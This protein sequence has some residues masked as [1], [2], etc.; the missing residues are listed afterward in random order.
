MINTFTLSVELPTRGE[1]EVEIEVTTKG[2][3]ENDG[4]GAYEYWGCKGV[5]RGT[6]YFYI[7]EWDWNKTGFSPDEIKSVEAAIEANVDKWA[8]TVKMDEP[9]YDDWSE[10]RIEGKD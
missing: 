5:D 10:D 9:D 4:I 3:W 1:D 2:D 6:T 8:D 7:E